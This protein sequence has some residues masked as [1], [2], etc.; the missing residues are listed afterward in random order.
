M[1]QHLTAV[2]NM[3]LMHC[4]SNN[5]N[6]NNY[7]SQKKLRHKCFGA[8]ARNCVKNCSD[9]GLSSKSSIMTTRTVCAA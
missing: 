5:N 6:N 2:G 3:K 4:R 9:V 7:N 1:L 8:Q